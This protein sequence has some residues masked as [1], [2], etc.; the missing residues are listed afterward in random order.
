M[1]LCPKCGAPQKNSRSTCIDCGTRLGKPLTQEELA[2]YQ[3]DH[4]LGRMI[5]DM[6]E[7]TDDFYVSRWAWV[8]VALNAV[9]FVA[10]LCVLVFGRTWA[11]AKL[12]LLPLIC[13]PAGA[14]FLAFPRLFWRLQQLRISLVYD[15]DGLSPSFYWIVMQKVAGVLFTAI[16]AAMTLVI[17]FG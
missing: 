13:A 3:L 6:A 7:R 17:Y 4:N 1:K 16:S 15:I 11:N 14:A 9:C 8:L 5:D 10:A 2:Q 12:V